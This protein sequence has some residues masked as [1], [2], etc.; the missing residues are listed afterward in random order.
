[1][2]GWDFEISF[3]RKFLGKTINLEP[4]KQLLPTDDMFLC[5]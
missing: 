4:L 2:E 1:M 5:R 3:G